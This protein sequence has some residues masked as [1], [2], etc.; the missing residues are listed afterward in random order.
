MKFISLVNLI[1]GREVVRELVAA[2]MNSKNISVE[3]GKLLGD[4]PERATMLREYERM[5]NIL[6]EAGAS[7][8]AAAI[9]IKLLNKAH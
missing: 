5:N 8:R 6:G 1:S 3:L 7:E 2:E 4:T 9:M